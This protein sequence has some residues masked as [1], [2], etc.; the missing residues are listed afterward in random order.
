MI[1]R[2]HLKQITP[3]R[4]QAAVQDL[5]HEATFPESAV[6]ETLRRAREYPA[7]GEVVKTLQQIGRQ[8]GVQSTAT[9]RV[10]GMK[11]IFEALISI[12]ESD[13]CN[14]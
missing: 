13:E 11:I 3:D 5:N 2:D 4:L 8:S 9:A 12:A 14:G 10:E 7:F 6:A 1:L